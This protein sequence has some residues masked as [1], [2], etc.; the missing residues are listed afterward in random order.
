M[1]I[2]GMDMGSPDPPRMD[3]F[4]VVL[5]MTDGSEITVPAGQ[6]LSVDLWRDYGR[7][8]FLSADVFQVPTTQLTLKLLVRDPVTWTPRRPP[9]DVTP[10]PKPLPCRPPELPPHA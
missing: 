8:D 1:E 5:R 2:S 3:L 9:R 7:P 4:E 10:K 6:I